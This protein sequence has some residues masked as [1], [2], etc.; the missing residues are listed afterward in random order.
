MKNIIINRSSIKLCVIQ[1]KTTTKMNNHKRK[2]K[3]KSK[4]K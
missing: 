3:E 1:T 2:R 4:Y